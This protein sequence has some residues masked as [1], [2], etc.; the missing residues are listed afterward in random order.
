MARWRSGKGDVKMKTQTIVEMLLSA[1]DL[2]TV[3]H[4][5]IGTI[6]D[7][8]CVSNIMKE[9]AERLEELDKKLAELESGRS[10]I[11][12]TGRCANETDDS[13]L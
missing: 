13:A 6:N 5:H 3:Q 2:F 12:P 11:A 4:S 9:A 1:A 10:M 8:Y 7:N